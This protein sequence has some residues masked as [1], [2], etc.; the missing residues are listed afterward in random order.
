MTGQRREWLFIAQVFANFAALTILIVFVVLAFSAGGK[1][2]EEQR[3]QNLRVSCAN[4]ETQR[5]ILSAL[6][7]ISRSLGIPTH[8]TIPEVPAECDGS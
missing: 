3:L 4:A 5:S 2:A 6:D 8:F 7:D 1:R